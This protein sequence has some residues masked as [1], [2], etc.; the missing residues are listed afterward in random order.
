LLRRPLVPIWLSRPSRF[1]AL[2]ATRA[3][4]GVGV[5]ASLML[6]TLLAL[7]TPGPPP[8]SG[9]PAERANDQAD[10]VLYETIVANIRHGGNYYRVAAEALRAGDYPLHPFVVFR[11]PTLAVI[12]AAMP[13]GVVVLLLY[14]LAAATA[15]AWYRRL[16]PSFARPPPLIL[17]MVL[18]AGGMMAFV[19]SDLRYFHEIWAGLFIALSLALHRRSDWLPAVAFGLAAALVRE[20]AAPYLL[21]MLAFALL[22]RNYREAAAWAGAL[23]VLIGALA[24]H[25]LAVAQVVHATDPVSP[26]WAGMLGFGFFVKTMA[27]STALGIAPMWLAAPLFGLALFGWAAWPDELGLRMLA[28]LSG[29]A[30]I[31]SIVGRVDTFYWGLL[32]APACL[33]GLAFSLD[34]LRDL[35]TAARDQRKITVTRVVR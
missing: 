18:L 5:L 30:V 9:N 15:L 17:A 3:R 22:D 2:S 8:V 1:A 14:I 16:A 25:A 12:E 32:V 13:D 11:L 24:A 33:V 7:G 26:G 29:Y 31:L 23:A 4:L 28:L 34:G 20:T 19:Q 10:V 6:A 27:I 21:L 35:V